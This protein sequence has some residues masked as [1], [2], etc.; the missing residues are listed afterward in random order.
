MN[1]LDKNR[2]NTG[3]NGEWLNDDEENGIHGTVLMAEDMNS[4]GTEINNLIKAG[5]M[6][7]NKNENDQIL[8]VVK[9]LGGS[10]VSSSASNVSYDNSISSLEQKN[11]DFPTFKSAIDDL[12][13][14]S[15]TE[16]S[17]M[18]KIEK[19]DDNYFLKGNVSV[20]SN[21]N[22]LPISL[23]IDGK[24]NYEILSFIGQFFNIDYGN[25]IENINWTDALENEIIVNGINNGWQFAFLNGI[26]GIKRKDNGE[27]PENTY[28]V[29]LNIK[30]RVLLKPDE[31]IIAWQYGINDN[32]V[33]KIVNENGN[34]KIKGITN[35]YAGVRSEETI[36]FTNS[37]LENYIDFDIEHRSG[38]TSSSSKNIIWTLK[39]SSSNYIISIKYTDSSQIQAND[40][41]T[42]DI[43]PDKNSN[44]DF[45]KGDAV[46][47]QNAID[48]LSELKQNKLTAGENIVIE[49]Q[50]E[51]TIIKS[52]GGGEAE[53]IGFDNTNTQ[54][55]QL[56]GYDFPKYK[57]TIPNTINLVLITGE[58]N[59]P[60]TITKQSDGSYRLNLSAQ[61]YQSTIMQFIIIHRI[62]TPH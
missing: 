3:L 47:V 59:I 20:T 60:T 34:T 8:K 42:I 7:P 22:V 49:K 15:L 6:T 48:S 33:L 51:S 2:L 32:I 29:T 43:T 10:G 45:T 55:E 16:S 36:F 19:E 57:K 37:I 25:D 27:L 24:D 4:L 39:K 41:F 17:V 58:G 35:T 14:I 30:N 40:F 5:G 54:L 12:T 23:T 13:Y 21:Q 9:N 46:N 61:T 18:G 44:I 62:K 50:G 28:S 26:L 1:L 11:Y 31:N 52:L 56:A 53:N 38:I